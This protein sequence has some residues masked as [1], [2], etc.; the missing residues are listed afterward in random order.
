MPKQ[1]NNNPTK[2]GTNHSSHHSKDRIAHY[3]TNIFG[4]IAFLISFLIATAG[5]I[6]YNSGMIK[7]IKPIDPDPYSKLELFLSAFAIFLSTAVLIS[8]KRQARLEKIAEQVEFEVNLRAE[9]EVTKVLGML[10]AIQEKLGIVNNDPE[11]KK[12]MKELD[13]KKIHDQQKRAE[14]KG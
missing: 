14:G 5:W 11:L 13:T 2:A 8:Q 3:I 1:K 9:K 6:I 10:Q 7:G 12:M 4:S